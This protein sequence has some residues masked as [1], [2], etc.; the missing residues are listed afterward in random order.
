MRKDLTF[1]GRE[2]LTWLWFKSEERNGTVALADGDVEVLF[3]QRIVLESGDGE[4][5]ETVVCNGRHCSLKEG[6]AAL[7]EGKRVKEARIRLSRETGEWEFTFKADRFHFQSLKLPRT[8]AEDE[9]NDRDGRILERIFLLETAVSI[10]DKLF[11]LFLDRRLSPDWT[12]QELR[13][14]K[15]WAMQDS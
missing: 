12:A 4:Y 2:F 9:E 11:S 15:K 6:K 3:V 14:M 8:A 10:M 5:A 7:R 13:R 1:L